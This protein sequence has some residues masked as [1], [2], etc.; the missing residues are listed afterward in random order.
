M[1]K[2]AFKRAIEVG[3]KGSS[4]CHEVCIKEKK[5]SVS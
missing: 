3:V 5:R 1:C 2:L 4:L